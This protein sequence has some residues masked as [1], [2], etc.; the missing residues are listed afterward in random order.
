MEKILLNGNNICMVSLPPLSHLSPTTANHHHYSSSQAV[1]GPW[2]PLQPKCGVMS[3]C[4]IV[5]AARLSLVWLPRGSG[6][7]EKNDFPN[8]PC[9]VRVSVRDRFL[10][11]TVT[12]M[13]SGFVCAAG[14]L[15]VL[16][17][18]WAVCVVAHG[19]PGGGAGRCP[20]YS[21]SRSPRTSNP[22]VA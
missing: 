19:D 1:K 22:P 14:R 2:V 20:P 11:V 10:A 15:C 17:P 9:L 21:K 4:P 3:I 5:L 7:L 13:Y 6:H 8:L 12:G 16:L 18:W